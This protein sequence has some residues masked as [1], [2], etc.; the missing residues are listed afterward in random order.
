MNEAAENLEFER[1]SEYRDQITDIETIM[2][3]QIINFNDRIDRD[4]FGYYVDKGWMCVQIFLCD[5]VT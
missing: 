3:K 1:A 4:V 5:K 2:T